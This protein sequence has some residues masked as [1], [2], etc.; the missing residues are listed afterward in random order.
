MVRRHWVQ[1]LRLG[2]VTHLEI[3][4]IETKSYQAQMLAACSTSG[5]ISSLPAHPFSF[6]V[7]CEELQAE[8]EGLW[9]SEPL[10]QMPQI[11]LSSE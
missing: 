10:P 3:C 1:C 2:R 4:R 5:R 8:S 6:H 9:H 7:T 11:V